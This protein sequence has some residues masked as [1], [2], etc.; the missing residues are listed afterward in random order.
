AGGH[1]AAGL[2]GNPARGG[3][4]GGRTPRR[5]G[6]T[7]ARDRS[8]PLLDRLTRRN[9]TGGRGGTAHTL[10]TRRASGRLRRPRT[11]PAPPRL[12]LRTPRA[13]TGPSRR[14][15]VGRAGRGRNTRARRGR[16]RCVPGPRGGRRPPARVPRGCGGAGA[17]GDL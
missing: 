15:H 6:G 12:T 5:R 11:R 4:P 13:R 7:A 3:G 9:R 10:A 14:G 8:I 16:G 17:V 2:P 1:R